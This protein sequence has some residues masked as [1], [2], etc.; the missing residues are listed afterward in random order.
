MTTS[1]PPG[2]F[3]F[4]GVPPGIYVLAG[5]MF[6]RVSSSVTV[7]L[8]AAGEVAA[9][10]RCSAPPTPN[11]RPPRTDPGPGRRCPDRQH[12]DLRPGRHPVPAAECLLT[13]SVMV[14]VIDPDTGRID[15]DVPAETVSATS[16]A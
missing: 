8:A 15:P 9:D 11:C 12:A 2:S 7:E 5:S 1:D 4:T 14:P 10:L 3:R 13:A 6:G 16:N